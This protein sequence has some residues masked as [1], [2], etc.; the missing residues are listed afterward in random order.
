MQFIDTIRRMLAVLRHDK[1]SYP[2]NTNIKSYTSRKSRTAL[3]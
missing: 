1:V 3:R 2:T